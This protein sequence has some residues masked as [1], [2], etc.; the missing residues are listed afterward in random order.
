[1]TTKKNISKTLAHEI[2]LPLIQASEFT[3]K[4]IQI[5]SNKLKSKNVKL[6]NF[7]TFENKM[8]V[9]RIGRNPKTKEC[10]IIHPRRRFFFRA[11]NKLK[12]I[13]N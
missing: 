13:L 12:K 8:S 5:I 4:F 3:N 11:S 10:Y 1:M 6:S 7:G 2:N 9:K